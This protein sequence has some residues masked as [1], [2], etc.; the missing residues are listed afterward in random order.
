M[1]TTPGVSHTRPPA[2][3]DTAAEVQCRYAASQQQR[4]HRDDRVARARHVEDFPGVGWMAGVLSVEP[5]VDAQFAQGQQCGL[6]L[7]E[8]VEAVESIADAGVPGI[9]VADSH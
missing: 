8:V 7:Q 1:G 4:G 2:R 5:D 3:F 9:G 6:G